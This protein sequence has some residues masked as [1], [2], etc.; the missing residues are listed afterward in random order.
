[1]KKLLILLLLPLFS[2]SQEDIE[3]YKVYD[4]ENIYTSILL[5]TATGQTWQLQIGIGDNSE[6]MRTVL[7]DSKYAQT[8]EELTDE[9][10]Y[11][12]EYWEE[13]Y[14]SKSDSIFSAEEK[15]MWKPA[16]VDERI[17]SD[18][19]YHLAQ[20]GRFKLY[21]TENTYNFIM[22]DVINGRTWQVQWNIDYDKR[23]CIRIR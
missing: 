8:L 5:D 12:L 11:Q 3:R 21:P 4:T 6:R 14:N 23:L 22:V 2:F 16:T 1:M 9:Y 17:Q 13:N 7:S 20:N 18:M 19:F 10:N 15:I